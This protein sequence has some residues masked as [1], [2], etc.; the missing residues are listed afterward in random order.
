M[1]SRRNFRKNTKSGKQRKYTYVHKKRRRARSH[2]R[3]KIREGAKSRR[4]TNM[5]GG[6]EQEDE[7]KENKADKLVREENCDK[8]EGVIEGEEIGEGK[9]YCTG[10]N[11]ISEDTINGI[12]DHRKQYRDPFTNKDYTRDELPEKFKSRVNAPPP[13]QSFFG[14]QLPFPASPADARRTNPFAPPVSRRGQRSRRRAAAPA[15]RFPPL[16]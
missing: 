6:K 3:T 14:D 5:R 11:C 15:R 16:H 8:I 9:G 2:R 7:C 4:R 12:I 13:L 10:F 1:K